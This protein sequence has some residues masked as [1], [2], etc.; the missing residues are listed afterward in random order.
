M[1]ITVYSGYFYH[2]GVTWGGSMKVT[3]YAGYFYH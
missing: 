3:V 2:D 1:E